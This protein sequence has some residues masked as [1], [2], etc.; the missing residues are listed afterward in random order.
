MARRTGRIRLET[1]NGRAELAIRREPYWLSL[2][3]RKHL[4]YRAISMSGRR[5][6][7]WIARFRDDEGKKHFHNLGLAD[8]AGAE[9]ARRADGKEVLTFE[10]ASEAAREWFAACCNPDRAKPPEPYTVQKA[11]SDYLHA[12][13]DQ[14][15]AKEIGYALAAPVLGR[16]AGIEV[17]KLTPKD[18]RDWHRGLAS[19]PPRLRTRQG[20]AARFKDTTDDP[21]AERKRK[22]TANRHLAYLKAALNRAFA[23]K[24][25]QVPANTAWTKVKPFENVEQPRTRYLTPE[26]C[27]RLIA[28][29]EADFAQI[30]QG[31]LYTGARYSELCRMD[32][33][34]M[35]PDS[36]TIA[37]R[38]SKSGKR[39]SIILAP[40]AAAFFARL[41]DGHSP[42]RPLFE[43]KD[44][45]R[46]AKSQQLTR[47]AE[48]CRSG[49]IAPSIGFHGLRHTYASLMVMNGAPLHVVADNL[50]HADERMVQ[51]HY[52]HLADSY[53]RKIIQD[54]APSFGFQDMAAVRQA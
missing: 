42:D 46:W 52:G 29:C 53:K 5:A 40:E 23:E 19:Q 33:A 21:E 32:V 45:K 22:V 41:I 36:S 25:D 4:G 26:E 17:P 18:I 49:G 43:R 39:R 7:T 54:T 11:V 51:R 6:G 14:P 28:A 10:D 2:G 20:E 15:S 9:N 8:D 16:L 50:G 37:V 38:Q 27:R 13:A 30:V 1:R 31:A 34:D 24:G 44:G 47:L 12:V 48:A 3:T 35:H